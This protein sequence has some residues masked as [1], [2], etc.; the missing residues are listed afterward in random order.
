M[1][2]K[3]GL[4]GLMTGLLLL[5]GGT[6]MHAATPVPFIT[7]DFD[8][9]E[10]TPGGT[11]TPF[12]VGYKFQVGAND[13][14][15]SSLGVPVNFV[16]GNSNANPHAVGLWRVSDQ[17]LL[18]STTVPAGMGN[19][20]GAYRYEAVAPTLLTAGAEYA[21]AAYVNNSTQKDTWWNGVDTPITG[22]NADPAG[23]SYL[24]RAGNFF[25][26]QDPT[27]AVNVFPNETPTD[28]THWPTAN[29]L[30]TGAAPVLSCVGFEPPMAGGPV[31]VKKNRALPLKGQLFD[32][33]GIVITD[34]DLTA[35]PVVQ[36]LFDSGG[37]GTAVDV[38]GQALPAGLGDDGN[39]FVYTGARWQYNLK[40]KNYT[41]P[42]TYT[43]SMASGDDAEYLVDPTCEAEFVIK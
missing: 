43:V 26:S 1:Q 5:A 4:C 29:F 41:A 27:I 39:Q 36:V 34:L 37:G 17:T 22:F 2:I 18:V 12:Y 15:V 19:Q 7:P 24:H 9:V 16:T 13:I 33:D 30:F 23:G 14:L 10:L 25:Q 38:S 40:T 31:K 6:A 42:G 32:S 28:T 21:I 35:P 3:R 20:I 8:T 11:G